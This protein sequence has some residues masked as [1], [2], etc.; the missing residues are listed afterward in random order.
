MHGRGNHSFF[1]PLDIVSVYIVN[2]LKN[3][4]N[5]GAALT[6]KRTDLNFYEN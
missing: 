1:L 2:Q 4:E 3:L 6:N 5:E